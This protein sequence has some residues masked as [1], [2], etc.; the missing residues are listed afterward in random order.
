MT[1]IYICISTNVGPKQTSIED[2]LDAVTKK[3]RNFINNNKDL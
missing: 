3:K 2:D 1:I